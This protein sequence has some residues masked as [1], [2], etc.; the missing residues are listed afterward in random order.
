MKDLAPSIKR[1]RLLIEGFYSVNVNELV[2]KDYFNK[3]TE[4]LNLR[5]Y[6]EPII[7]SPAGLGKEGNQGYDA[8][9]PLI[10]SGISLY[11][12]TKEKFLSAIIYTCKDFAQ[13]QAVKSTKDFFEMNNLE[14]ESF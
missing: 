14:M 1:Q 9:V 11:V 12:W 5:I 4:D 6:S 13:D 8:F 3:I 7:F 2:I 10:D